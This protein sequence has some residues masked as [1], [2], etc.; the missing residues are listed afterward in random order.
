MLNA[1]DL[2]ADVVGAARAY[3]SA[4]YADQNLQQRFAKRISSDDG[5]RPQARRVVESMGAKGSAA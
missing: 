5:G 2:Y 1:E 4:L 3:F